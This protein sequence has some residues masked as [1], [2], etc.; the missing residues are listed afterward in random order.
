[1]EVV[2]VELVE[3]MR[4]MNKNVGWF[5]KILGVMNEIGRA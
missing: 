5:D 1:M 4:E 2:V 3:A